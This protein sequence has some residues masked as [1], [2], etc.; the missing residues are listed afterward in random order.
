[1][2]S[3]LKPSMVGIITPASSATVAGKPKLGSMNCKRPQ[4]EQKI[5]LKDLKR[6]SHPRKSEQLIPLP[7]SSKGPIVWGPIF[8]VN[9]YTDP[10]RNIPNISQLY[11]PA[12]G[13][14]GCPKRTTCYANPPMHDLHFARTWRTF[15]W[16]A[17]RAQAALALCAASFASP[18]GKAATWWDR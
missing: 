8:M 11:P 6:P 12:K 17:Q 9:L 2:F 10:M 15:P 18:R 1:M 3:S 5:P 14:T 4:G 7:P 16:P 13:A